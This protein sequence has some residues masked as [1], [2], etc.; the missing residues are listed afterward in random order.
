VEDHSDETLSRRRTGEVAFSWKT[1][2]E[3][4][5]ATEEQNYIMRILK[6]DQERDSPIQETE[7]KKRRK[8]KTRPYNKSLSRER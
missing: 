2:R 1:V 7:G 8:K 4:A 5:K 3:I 6:Q